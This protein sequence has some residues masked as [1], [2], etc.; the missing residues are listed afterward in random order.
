MLHDA[1][2]E[3]FLAVAD[4]VDFNLGATEVLIDEHRVIL[5]LAQDNRHVFVDVFIAVCNDHVLTAEY[6]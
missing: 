1:R 3:D 2:D 4:G 5:L 6:V